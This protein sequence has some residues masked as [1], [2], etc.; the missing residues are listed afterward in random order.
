MHGELHL[1]SAAPTFSSGKPAHC[2]G[3]GEAT[4][5]NGCDAGSLPLGTKVEIDGASQPGTL[6]YSSW[7]TMQGKNETD[8]NACDYNDLALV[9]IDPADVGQVNPS[10]PGFG[11]PQHADGPAPTARTST[12]TATP[13]C[14]ARRRNHSQPQEGQGPLHGRRRLDAHR[15]YVSLR[16]PRATR[17]AGSFDA[18]DNAFGT[19]STVQIAPHAGLERSVEPVEGAGI[20]EAPTASAA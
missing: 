5:T 14:A 10:V 4:E 6:V 7:L 18:R 2:A 1:P 9:E 15:L 19:L 12:P 16:H 11:G 17:A 3:T 8:G 20:R 13:R